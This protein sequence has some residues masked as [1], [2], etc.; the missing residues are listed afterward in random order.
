MG[1]CTALGLLRCWRLVQQYLW[2]VAVCCPRGAAGLLVLQAP[3]GECPSNTT[4]AI[5]MRLPHAVYV[6]E[7][8]AAGERGVGSWLAKVM[9]S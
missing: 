8:V 7:G 9:H 5:A 3:P 2:P 4:G 6:E 1:V